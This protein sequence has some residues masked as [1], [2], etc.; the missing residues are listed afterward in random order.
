M[1]KHFEKAQNRDGMTA[2]LLGIW[3]TPMQRTHP[4]SNTRPACPAFKSIKAL[5]TRSTRRQFRQTPDSGTVDTTSSACDQLAPSKTLKQ[6]VNC[7][8][9]KRP[10]HAAIPNQQTYSSPQ[11]PL[12]PHQPLMY[13]QMGH[14]SFSRGAP[15]VCYWH[16]NGSGVFYMKPDGE[17]LMANWKHWWTDQQ[18]QWR[19]LMS[20]TGSE[21]H[22]QGGQYSFCGPAD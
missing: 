4:F 8:Q 22:P 10:L 14:S 13:A 5:N 15:H 16:L 19:Q 20:H 11:H 7:R 17:E 1:P 9:Q 6:Q 2:T 12:L 3:N 18:H 21:Q